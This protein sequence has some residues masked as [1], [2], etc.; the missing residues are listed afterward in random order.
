MFVGHVPNQGTIRQE[1]D[2]H[3]R[4]GEQGMHDI[5]ISG[6]DLEDPAWM[7]STQGFTVSTRSQAT[8][9]GIWRVHKVKPLASMAFISLQMAAT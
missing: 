2:V 8:Y 9:V 1:G 5:R 6:S 3:G 7:V 4:K